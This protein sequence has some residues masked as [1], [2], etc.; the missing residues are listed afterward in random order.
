MPTIGREGVGDGWALTIGEP[1][2]GWPSV[3]LGGLPLTHS[4]TECLTARLKLN[5][6]FDGFV[7]FLLP[8]PL[9]LRRSA[10]SNLFLHQHQPL[11]EKI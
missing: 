2:L 9:S 1:T 6:S 10:Q 7:V 8:L 3:S 11:V 5:L 4:S